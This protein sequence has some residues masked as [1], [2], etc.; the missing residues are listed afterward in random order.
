MKTIKLTVDASKKTI[1]IPSH[2]TRGYKG[3]LRVTIAKS[4]SKAASSQRAARPPSR[5]RYDFSA[6]AG[7]LSWRGDAVKEQRKLR[8]EWK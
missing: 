2:F 1:R 5:P 3:T 4:T 6:V 8:N 7:K